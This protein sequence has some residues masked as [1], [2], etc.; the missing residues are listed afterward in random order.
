MKSC[1]EYAE[2]ITMDGR[3]GP[4]H[5]LS[6]RHGFGSIDMRLKGNGRGDG[7]LRNRGTWVNWTEFYRYNVNQR[8]ER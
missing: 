4:W 7:E 1:P 8:S 6:F 3:D 2:I 5:P